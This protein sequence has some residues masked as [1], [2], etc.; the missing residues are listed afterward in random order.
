[1]FRDSWTDQDQRAVE[2]LAKKF[3]VHLN[4]PDVAGETAT[5]ASIEAAASKIGKAVTQHVT[6]DLALQQ[7]ALLG[8]PQPCPGCGKLCLVEV[9]DREL[10]TG[11]VPIELHETAC[12]CSACR[13][14]F[15][16]STRPI[17]AAST[18]L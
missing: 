16:P 15:F 1:M 17:G 11:E 5:F 10:S 4:D 3:G 8:E 6:Q 18:R 13:R 9:R 12:H 14:D 2:H 7:T